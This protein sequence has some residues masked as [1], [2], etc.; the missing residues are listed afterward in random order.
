M[1]FKYEDIYVCEYL[2]KRQSS[3]TQPAREER[4]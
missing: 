3:S 4:W 2:A 1:E